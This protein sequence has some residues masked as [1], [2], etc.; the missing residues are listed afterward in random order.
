MDERAA[1]IYEVTEIVM[2]CRPLDVQRDFI[3]GDITRVKGVQRHLSDVSLDL[4]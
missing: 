2:C 4:R 3:M 1:A